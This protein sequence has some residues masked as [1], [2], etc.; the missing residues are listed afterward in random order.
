MGLSEL[1]VKVEN[2]TKIYKT[3]KVNFF[4]FLEDLTKGFLPQIQGRFIETK[5]GGYFWALKNINFEVKKGEVVGI[6]GKNGS[7]KSTLLKIMANVTR[8]TTGKIYLDGRC[9][10]ILEV[11]VGFQGEF[12][13]RENIYL[14]AAMLGMR[15]SEI[16]KKFDEIV[17]FSGIKDFI[18]M[19]VKK[20][21]SGMYI[22]LGFAVAA[23]L[24]VE[25]LLVD[26]ALAVGDFEFQEKAL[27]K[28]LKLVK[29]G[30]T[31]IF[32][33]HNLNQI[34]SLTNRAILLNEGELIFDGNVK[35]CLNKYSE[36]LRKSSLPEYYNPNVQ[37][38]VI[39]AKVKT[40]NANGIHHTG[41]PLIFEFEINFAKQPASGN[42]E[43]QIIDALQRPLLHFNLSD[44]ERK[45]SRKGPVYVKC[46][47]PRPRLAIGKY[48]LRTRLYDKATLD[49]Y[50]T[51]NA[52]C[53][54][55]IHLND[56]FSNHQLNSNLLCSY[57]EEY[58]WEI[59]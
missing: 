32:V 48:T 3:K 52:I 36:I 30:Q 57:Y 49:E 17:E 41:K 16:D 9:T 39:A 10:A 40:S 7:G 26:E 34:T 19:P 55:E 15:K 14:S 6:I 4:Y 21:S 20:Y 53:P 33:S 51:L 25:I 47:L 28:M 12:T 11:G 54:F 13:G 18:D 22:R 46:I 45:W 50:E 29:R 27:K 31:I 5:K 58:E 43:F 59:S 42:F 24:D 56:D 38:G 35:E 44:S 23:H 37:T 2:V 8:P 1:A